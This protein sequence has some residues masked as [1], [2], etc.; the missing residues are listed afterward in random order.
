MTTKWC[1]VDRCPDS[2]PSHQVLDA[3]CAVIHFM[4]GD[5]EHIGM[6]ACAADRCTRMLGNVL[7]VAICGVHYRTCMS[8]T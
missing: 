7:V 1:T 8:R 6:H 4:S 2:R 3:Q 5:H